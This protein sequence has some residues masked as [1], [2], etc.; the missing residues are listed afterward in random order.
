[1]GWTF[2]I[3]SQTLSFYC[4]FAIWRNLKF[5]INRNSFSLANF[6]VFY[7]RTLLS[8]FY[9]LLYKCIYHSWFRE[10]QRWNGAVQRWTTIFQN[11][12]SQCWPTLIHRWFYLEQSFPVPIRTELF[13]SEEPWFAKSSVWSAVKQHWS[14]LVFFVFC[15]SVLNSAGKRQITKSVLIC[16][17]YIWDLS[18]VAE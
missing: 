2:K 8:L 11:W 16:A 17:D 5:S 9:F 1:M 10:D 12:E 6:G 15:G 18:P 3:A 7:F 14:P 13:R 4:N